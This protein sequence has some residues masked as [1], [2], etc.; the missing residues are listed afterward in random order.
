MAGCLWVSAIAGSAE[1]GAQAEAAAGSRYAESGAGSNASAAGRSGGWV[2]LLWLGV[3][4]VGG[5][6]GGS[7]HL[8]EDGRHSFYCE[9]VLGLM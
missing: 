3:V 9:L 4:E 7:L 1:A 8:V 2:K 6:V 5:G